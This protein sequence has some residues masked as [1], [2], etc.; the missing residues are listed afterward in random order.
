MR[1]NPISLLAFFLFAAAQP[2]RP[3]TQISQTQISQTQTA[4]SL[5]GS[6]LPDAPQPQSGPP[7]SIPAA[8][9]SAEAASVFGLV[10]DS[11]GALVLGA[12]VTLSRS[13]GTQ[14]NTAKSGADGTFA[15]TQ[16]PPGSYSLTVQAGGFSPY[17]S[18][19][20]VL[21]A[22][23]SY[24]LPHIEL[25][26]A[27]AN[28]EVTVRP[29]DEVAAEQLRAEE[30]QRVFGIIPA[31]FI[32]FVYDAAPLTTR[33]KF[34]LTAH[35]T[36]DPVSFVGVGLRAGI[37]QANNTY[38]G[39]GQ[40]AAGYG[41]RYA[42]ALGDSLTSDFLGHAVFPSL[43]H[44]D[45]RYFYQGSGT[46]K[47]RI[48]HAI[49]FSVLLRNDRGGLSPNYSYLLGDIGSGALSNLYYPHADRGAGL[50]FSNAAI[51][52][53]GRAAGAVFREFFAKRVVS[54]VPG[55]GKP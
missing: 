3:Q 52:I 42:A 29:Q 9:S 14:R 5:S 35:D 33:Q 41:K 7:S 31:Y 53:G 24:N 21:T 18:G 43:F 8:S 19:R 54:N 26:I 50:V 25:Q 46:R 11:S 27:G 34:S 45:P 38:A 51:G 1:L 23:Q 37:E 17:T 13:T 49:E 15:F 22:Q 36:L 4:R 28:T 10:E 2:G 6:D 55:D 39:Y 47:A 12:T 40:G 44:Q 30:K 32:S 20:F 48:Y 16:L